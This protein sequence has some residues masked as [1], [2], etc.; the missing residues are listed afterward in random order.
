MKNIIERARWWI[1][2]PR[3]ELI[4]LLGGVPKEHLNTL[5][6]RNVESIIRRYAF[7]HKEG[8]SQLS[9]AKKTKYRDYT[10]G[11]WTLFKLVQVRKYKSNE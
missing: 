6:Y 3:Y 5:H 4:Y 10:G 11:T 7:S 8:I 2:H 9:H 1:Y